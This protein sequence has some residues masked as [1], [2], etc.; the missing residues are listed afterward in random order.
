MQRVGQDRD[1]VRPCSAHNFQQRKAYIE[2]KSKAE[3]ARRFVNRVRVRARV[4]V[5]MCLPHTRF[6]PFDDGDRFQTSNRSGDV[7][8]FN[9]VDNGFNLLVSQRRFFC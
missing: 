7:G 3:T 1:T 9:H 5:L 2:E 6:L 4:R 8:P